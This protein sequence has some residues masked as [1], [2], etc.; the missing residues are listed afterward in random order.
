VDF[1]APG[2][3]VPLTGRGARQTILEMLALTDWRSLDY[4]IVDMP[5]ATSDI[6]MTLTSLAK[7]ELSAIIVTMPDKLSLTVA[8]RVMQ[9]LR[10]GQIPVT[11]VLGNMHRPAHQGG[12][13]DEDGPR[14][15]AEEFNTTFLGKIPYDAK[16]QKAVE[17]SD[18]GGLLR[19]AFGRALNRSVKRY[20]VD[21]VSRH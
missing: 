19:T 18:I 7:R 17:D 20:L 8:H 6:M 13:L 14:R 2:K 4:L 12:L 11:G 10:S 16:V 5:P 3:P 21:R 1:F 9:L 15:L